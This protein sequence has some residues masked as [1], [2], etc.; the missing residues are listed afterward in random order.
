MD[1]PQE[2]LPASNRSR[3]IPVLASHG[4]LWQHW[5]SNNHGVRFMIG[6][7]RQN[8]K[9]TYRREGLTSHFKRT[10]E[11]RR[12]CVQLCHARKA[13]SRHASSHQAVGIAC[14]AIQITLL[15]HN[16][17]IITIIWYLN[18]VFSIFFLNP[19]CS[20]RYKMIE[21]HTQRDGMWFTHTPKICYN[22]C[23][24]GSTNIRCFSQVS[25][26]II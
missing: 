13:R 17:L 1:M 6:H 14:T 7:A 19:W 24:Y 15:L 10:R 8:T 23:N 11:N 21:I 16:L 20:Y 12:M 22:N 9:S 4:S 18:C 3:N 25:V 2:N 26:R 5:A